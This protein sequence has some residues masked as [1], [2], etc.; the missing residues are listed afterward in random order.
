VTN[1][2]RPDA[3]KATLD[4][5]SRLLDGYQRDFAV[6]FWDGTELEPD[7]GGPA[8]L[9]LVLNHPGSLRA[10]LARP[11]Q[12]QLSL[13][14]AFLYRD[15]DF[16]GDLERVFGLADF[17]LKERSWGLSE[18]IWAARAVAALPRLDATRGAEG[19]P[20]LRGRRDSPTR[21]AE[22]VRYH[23]DLDQDFYGLFLDERRVYTCAYY[24]SPTEDIGVAQERK[25]DY[26]CRKLRLVPGERLLDIG[27]GWGGLIIHAVERFDVEALGVTLS[28]PQAEIA[29]ERIR[30]A[31][32]ADRCKVQ[33]HDYREVGGEWDKVSSVGMFEHLSERGLAE[34]FR[35]VASIL[36]P[37]G[38]FLNHGI[39]ERYNKQ[40]RRGRSFFM[41][42]IFPDC[43]LLPISSTLRLA[44]AAGLEVR[45]VE[46]LREHYALTA[47]AWRRR[48]EANYDRAVELVGEPTYR[49][50]RL[51]M[52]GFAWGQDTGELNLWQ[53]LL[54]KPASD[55]ASGLPLQRADWYE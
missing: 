38:A 33:V 43:V 26:I 15:I 53:S 2:P 23:Y 17:L 42:Y 54:V 1:S 37:G 22:A 30:A 13:A 52:A 39:G 50:W 12:L 24:E 28:A 45:D 31:G 32:L 49:V 25:L 14:E 51:G 48:L 27:C 3:R 9:T 21:L 47:R 5:L 19:P 20:R 40:Q 46:S 34:Y 8:R 16:E 41:S 7:R 44:E 35:H 10:M 18:K 4:V 55:G 11:W 29:T 6:R 36:R